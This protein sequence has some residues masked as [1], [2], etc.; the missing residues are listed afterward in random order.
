MY[1]F[2]HSSHHAGFRLFAD[3]GVAE[4]LGEFAGPEGQVAALPAQGADALFQCQQRLV[5]LGALH[6]CNAQET[7]SLPCE[8]FV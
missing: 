7:M 2:I 4:D 1:V 5:D 8:Q 6:A 3:E